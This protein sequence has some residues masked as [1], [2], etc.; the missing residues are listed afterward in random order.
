MTDEELLNVR[1]VFEFEILP[2]PHEEPFFIGFTASPLS[3][4][5]F[6]MTGKV[7]TLSI[8]YKME[9]YKRKNKI[10]EVSFRCDVNCMC[11]FF[12][13]FSP[14]HSKQFD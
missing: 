2:E 9:E 7:A 6:S 3:A 12:F 10:R 13:I 8:A 11:V 1:L 4:L 14:Y 5:T